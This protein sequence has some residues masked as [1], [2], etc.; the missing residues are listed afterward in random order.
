[1]SHILHCALV[2]KSFSEQERSAIKQ[3]LCDAGLAR[4]TRQGIRAVRVSD[5]CAD[6]GIAKGSFYGFFPS[7]EELFM[8]IADSR[9]SLHQHDMLQFLGSA[10]GR[11]SEVLAAFFD[12]LVNKAETDPVLKVV[13][14][15]GELRHLMRKLPPERLSVNAERD[16]QFL[17]QVSAVL[18]E[19]KLSAFATPALLQSLLSLMLALVMQKDH[20]P[21]GGYPAAVQLLKELFVHRLLKGPAHD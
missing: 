15:H 17:E 14:E 6:V 20:M 21:L 13:V 18:G 4:F 8:S 19:R 2:P 9:D 5:L 12:M 10:S 1:M 7:K 16:R 11:A 3:A